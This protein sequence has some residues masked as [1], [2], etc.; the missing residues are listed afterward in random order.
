MGWKDCE[1][2]NVQGE[3]LC[4]GGKCHWELWLLC[5]CLRAVD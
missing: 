2:I 1:E 4:S 5:A 3:R